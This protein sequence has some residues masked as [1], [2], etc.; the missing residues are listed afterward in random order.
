MLAG[1]AT[2]ITHYVLYEK[3]VIHYGSVMEMDF[4][5]GTWGFFVNAAVAMLVSLAT[6]KK[7]DQELKGLVFWLREKATTQNPNWMLRPVTL[8]VAVAALTIT[9]NVI[10]R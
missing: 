7:S 1:F 8:A 9:L 4:Y 10:F 5:D 3:G 2:A 6:R